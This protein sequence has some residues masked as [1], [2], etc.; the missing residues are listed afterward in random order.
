MV[1]TVIQFVIDNI[2]F[3][4]PLII[5]GFVA[6]IFL[7]VTG[8]KETINKEDNLQED[9][10]KIGP[11][12]INIFIFFY[13]FAWVVL[14]LLGVLADFVIPTIIN[15]LIALIPVILLI[16]TQ[17]HIREDSKAKDL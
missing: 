4:L 7:Y 10:K 8:K 17:K 9:Y 12:H 5:V 15:A 6:T 13:L 14:V 1:K 16:L 2:F 3:I 11:L